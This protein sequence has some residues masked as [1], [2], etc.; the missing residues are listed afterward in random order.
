MKKSESITKLSAALTIAQAKMPSAKMNAVNPFLKNKYADL[1]SVIDCAKE[2][3]AANGLSIAQFP[4]G[5][6]E[7]IGVETI[8]MHSSGEWISNT[9]HLPLGTEKGKS[10]AQVA[11][12]IIS[13]LRRYSYA[14]VLG[15]YS[16][17]DSDGN[18][19]VKRTTPTKTEPQTTDIKSDSK[20]TRPMDA[21]TTKAALLGKSASYQSKGYTTTEKQ[22]KL[23]S[24]AYQNLFIDNNER[25]AA[26]QWL[27]GFTSSKEFAG[28]HKRA[29]ID[30]LSL[31]KTE[32]GKYVPSKDA[33][34]ESKNIVLAALHEQGQQEMDI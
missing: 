17:E 4:T 18:E 5:E 3:L 23:F 26:T 1:G 19:P 34:Q 11:G 8:L 32:D 10:E 15:I 31:E 33:L 29:I 12:S 28:H 13:Y 25:Y 14:S 2:T 27:F 22:D 30:W 6:G 16:D 20:V 21:E 24:I 7:T 9:I